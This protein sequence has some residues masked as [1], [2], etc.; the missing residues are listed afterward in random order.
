MGS[1]FRLFN[2]AENDYYV[3]SSG[4]D[5]GKFIASMI[6]QFANYCPYRQVLGPPCLGDTGTL[7]TNTF[8]APMLNSSTI[9]NWCQWQPFNTATPMRGIFN[10]GRSPVGCVPLA[11]GQIMAHNGFPNRS[12]NGRSASWNDIRQFAFWEDGASAT[13]TGLTVAAMLYYTG[14]SVNARYARNFTFALPVNAACF[15]QRQGYRNVRLHR[16]Y[17][18]IEIMRMVGDR[19]PVF[20][21]AISGLVNGHA[22]VIDGYQI[23]I[24]GNTRQVLLHCVW[25]WRGQANGWYASGIFNTRDGAVIPTNP[26]GTSPTFSGNYTWWFRIITYDLP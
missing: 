23:T 12:W 8:V 11:L 24:R 16:G 5:V 14:C 15:L 20:I 19:K 3:A 17:N 2:A 21:A 13:N 1:D 18:E 25:G 4:D 10:R 26:P 6:V 9:A 7:P 22:W